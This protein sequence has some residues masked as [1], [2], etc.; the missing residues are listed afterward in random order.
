MA[1]N[2]FAKLA[3]YLAGT[4]A[5]LIN[6]DENES[7]PDD[8]AGQIILYAAEVISLVEGGSEDLPPLPDILRDSIAGRISGA[9]RT[10]IIVI[11]GPLTVARFQLM[12]T[13]PRLARALGYVSQVLAALSANRPLPP[14]PAEL[15]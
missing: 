15:A 5:T 8:I 1:T 9:A 3:P 14:A 10:T 4:G 2:F 11:T 12:A 7:G 6:L 13:K